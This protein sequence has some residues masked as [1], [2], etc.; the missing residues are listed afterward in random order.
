LQFWFGCKETNKAISKSRLGNVNKSA[1]WY[2]PLTCWRN[3]A[4]KSK[5]PAAAQTAKIQLFI[6]AFLSLNFF[7]FDNLVIR[8]LKLLQLKKINYFLKFCTISF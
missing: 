4:F 2:E 1:C 7:I 5:L 3:A 6:S 8:A